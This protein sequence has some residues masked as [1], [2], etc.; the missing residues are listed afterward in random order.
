[1]KPHPA[2]KRICFV[3]TLMLVAVFAKA[4]PA[5]TTGVIKGFVYDKESGEPEVFTNVFLLGTK[6]GAQTDVNGYFT[7]TQVPPGHYTLFTSLIG[8]DTAKIEV[9]IKAGAVIQRKLFLGQKSKELKSVE[10]SARKVEKTTQVNAGSITVTPREIKLMPSSGGEPD[11]AQYLQVVPGVTF[12]GDQGGQLYIRGGAPSQ[13]GILLD[14]VTIYNPFHSIGLY[15]VFETDAIR[16]ADIQTAGFN[17][18]YGNRTSAIMDIHTKDGN[19]NRLAGKVSASPIMARAMLEGPLIKAKKEGGAV[20]TFLFSAKYSYLDKTSKALY[21]GFGEPYTSGLPYNF[22]DLYGKITINLDNGSKFNFFGFNF[23]DKVTVLSPITHDATADAHWN[24]KGAGMTF[25]VTPGTSA[26]L[27][28]GRFAYSKYN[29]DYN[30]ASFKPRSSGIDGFEGAID[31]TYYLPKYSEFKYGIEVSGTHT[32]LDYFTAAGSTTQLDR[33]NT[34]AAFYMM[35]RKN[36]GDKL[37]FEP[38]VRIQYYSS[39]NAISPEPRL[40]LKYNLS[41]TVRLKA[42]TGLYS[43]NIISTKSDRDIVNYFTGFLLSPDQQVQ[44][45]D[46]QVI[47]TNLQRA[48][49]VLAG[50][51]VDVQNVEFN[52][53]PWLKKFTQNIEL[54]RIKYLT[55]DAD[56]VSGNGKAYGIDLSAR[57]NKHHWYLWGVVSY[58][59]VRYETLVREGNKVNGAIEKQTYPPPFDR[60]VN[61]NLV[62]SYT[63]GKKRDWELSAR[64]NYGSPFPFTQTQGYFENLNVVQSGTQTNILTQNAPIGVVYATDINGGRLSAYHRLDISA[65]KRFELSKTSNIETTLSV[66]NV[67][68]RNNI[69]YVDRIQNVKVYQLPIFPSLTAAWNF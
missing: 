34:M 55:S 26:A 22:A 4:Q 58:Q 35:L 5:T 1:M 32:S 25:V 62:A 24:G 42:A 69:F 49:H 33:R 10:I 31:F 8:Y 17:A 63:A 28:N 9:D 6:I 7:I 66:S 68:D 47:N 67:Y 12:T 46:Q 3:L 39:L 23:D 50:V 15:S 37:I 18:Q 27:I 36:F 13:T 54:S 48:Y 43:Q 19:K 38:G 29:I 21:S 56:F 30:E 11:I 14:G 52:L 65:K 53:E 57:Y 61:I 16:S 45:T 41:N 20:T 51:E 60:R 2:L 64:F 44:N 40:G 59:N